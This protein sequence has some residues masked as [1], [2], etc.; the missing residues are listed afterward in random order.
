MTVCGAGFAKD[1]TNCAFIVAGQTSSVL[2]LFANAASSGAFEE[3]KKSTKSKLS[4]TQLENL[5]KLFSSA[6]KYMERLKSAAKPLESKNPS[7]FSK[8]ASAFFEIASD[9]EFQ[10][11]IS[12]A[13]KIYSISQID[14]KY[15]EDAYRNFATLMSIFDPSGVFDVIAN[16]MY[17][18]Y[19]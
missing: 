18:T 12:D 9:P 19:K 10:K 8:V 15:P 13:A 2:T 1:A 4:K 17:P 3:L 6:Q 16:Y 11:L 5:E 14:P 7:N